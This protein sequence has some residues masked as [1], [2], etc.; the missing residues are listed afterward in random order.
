VRVMQRE[1][2]RGDESQRRDKT[3]DIHGGDRL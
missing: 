3:M 1:T 2:Y